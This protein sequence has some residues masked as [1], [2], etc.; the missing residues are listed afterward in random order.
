MGEWADDGTKKHVPGNALTW[1][2]ATITPLCLPKV[3]MNLSIMEHAFRMIQLDPVG[4][5]RYIGLYLQNS[6]IASTSEKKQ[7]RSCSET[8]FQETGIPSRFSRFY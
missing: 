4:Q 3:E 1:T 8:E 2:I 5:M 7:K 6:I